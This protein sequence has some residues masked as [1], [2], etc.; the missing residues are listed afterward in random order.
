MYRQLHE[1]SAASPIKFR[2]FPSTVCRNISHESHP[3]SH[4]ITLGQQERL[5]IFGGAL[6]WFIG[7]IAF[8]YFLAGT[9]GR[10][11]SV[12]LFY[13]PFIGLFDTLYH[14]SRGQIPAYS[15]QWSVEN[16]W[17][18]NTETDLSQNVTNFHETWSKLR[19]DMDSDFFA[20]PYWVG[21]V[22]ALILVAHVTFDY[23]FLRSMLEC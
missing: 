19:I 1:P 23:V 8:P 6:H 13:T 2:E 5:H 20:L 7:I 16:S 22:P 18:D 11:F 17:F 9:G 3:W 21:T 4:G 14:S 15:C 10:I 12:I